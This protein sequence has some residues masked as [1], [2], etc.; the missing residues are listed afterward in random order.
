MKY[1]ILSGVLG[2]T[3]ERAPGDSARAGGDPTVSASGVEIGAAWRWTSK[4]N[5][6]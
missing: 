4:D 2:F 5:R 6:S 1:P 3:V